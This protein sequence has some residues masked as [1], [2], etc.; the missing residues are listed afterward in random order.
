MKNVIFLSVLILGFASCT[1]S[2]DVVVSAKQFDAITTLVSEKQFEFEADWAYPMS[3]NSL[4][5]LS[6]AGLLGVGNSSARVNLIGNSNYIRFTK[7]SVSGDLPFY[8]ERKISSFNTVNTGISFD[9]IPEDY[10][11]KVDIENQ[12]IDI[13]FNISE[14]TES[15]Q[16]N[17]V[18]F[19]NRKTRVSINSSHRN[20]IR[21]DG[22]IT[23][24]KVLE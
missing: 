1:S 18:I 21:Y 9:G 3:T 11:E 12:R 20:T 2:K 14:K 7:D 5:Q 24:L 22:T 15:L 4:S 10:E 6:N 16:V 8:G 19:G 13:R 17:I 23:Q